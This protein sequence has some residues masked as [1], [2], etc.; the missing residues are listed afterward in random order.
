MELRGGGKEETRNKIFSIWSD[1]ENRWLPNT[2]VVSQAKIKGLSKRTALLYMELLCK[3]GKME[4]KPEGQNVLYRLEPMTWW[5]MAHVQKVDWV[6]IGELAKFQLIARMVSDKYNEVVD[7]NPEDEKTYKLKPNVPKVGGGVSPSNL[8]TLMRLTIQLVDSLKENLP[9]E[10]LGEG[11]A[12]SDLYGLLWD[13]CTKVI[14]AYMDAWQ[15][16]YKTPGSKHK[17][18][19]YMAAA[20]QA[21]RDKREKENP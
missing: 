20:E 1:N 18:I 16:I 19:D 12:P 17:F 21:I 3:Q 11:T 6:S 7:W 9:V 10:Y 5:I 14:S 8:K 13:N 4:R 15:F 2:E